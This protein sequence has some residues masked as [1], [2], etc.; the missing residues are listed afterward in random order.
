M[1][2]TWYRTG[3]LTLTKGSAVAA[4]VNTAFLT[5]VRAGDMLIGPLMDM[6]EITEVIAD[7]QLRLASEYKGDDYTGPE[8]SVAPTTVQLKALALQI[9]SLVTLYQEVPE[10]VAGSALAAANSE[11]A[12]KA[13]EAAAKAS[14]TAAKEAQI[15]TTSSVTQAAGYRD[16]ALTY[17]NNANAA[18]TNAKAS[19]NSAKTSAT[20]AKTSETNAKASETNAA[21]SAAAAAT[22]VD[23]LYEDVASAQATANAA[24]PSLQKGTAGGVA[25]LNERGNITVR[26]E[27]VTLPSYRIGPNNTTA[28]RFATSGDLASIKHSAN[29]TTQIY[30][31]FRVPMPNASGTMMSLDFKAQRLGSGLT[32]MDCTVNLY[33]L[34]TPSI[35]NCHVVHR[36]NWR[37][38]VSV[39]V[40][41]GGELGIVFDVN[42]ANSGAGFFLMTLD[43]A[44]LGHVGAVDGFAWL[45]NWVAEAVVDFS[46]FTTAPTALPDTGP[47]PLAGGVMTGPLLLPLG[48]TSAA[49]LGVGAANTGLYSGAAGADVTMTVNGSARARVT[50]SDTR[51]V[52]PLGFGGSVGASDVTLSRTGVS[53]LSVGAANGTTFSGVVNIGDATFQLSKGTAGRLDNTPATGSAAIYLSANPGDSTST[54][55]IAINRFSST[56]GANGLV[57]YGGDGTTA[58]DHR[59]YGGGTVGGAAALA[60]IAARGGRVGIGGANTAGRTLRVYGDTQIDARL[61]IGSYTIA[62]L[63]TASAS[64]GAMAICSNA[65]G[66][67][68]VAYCDGTDWISLKTGLPVAVKPYES[69]TI[70][71]SQGVTGDWTA[72]RF[73]DGSMDFSVKFST[74][75][76]ALAG[77][78]G[79]QIAPTPM[80]Y[81]VTFT[82]VQSIFHDYS[83]G[84]HGTLKTS[85]PLGVGAAPLPTSNTGALYISTM[86]GG[87]DAT[88]GAVHFSARGRW[89][90]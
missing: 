24:I 72:C 57:V 47:M 44:R 25:A 79:V 43:A 70:T 69:G 41:T 51:L 63:P 73:P 18:E 32:G 5:N 33:V 83:G 71:P 84:W 19:E 34:A 1:A 7:S 36:G 61:F 74:P 8:W 39:G 54:A 23:T 85:S 46:S 81:P 13:S 10:D 49:A 14:E 9:A 30:A 4:G 65:Q 80:T 90:A 17:S 11:A 82:S 37:P 42:G 60:D 59:L 12:A 35:P 62:T 6:Y 86:L 50:A 68:S 38:T 2:G 20:N 88:S 16:N 67:A 53:A 77:G 45:S 64:S 22:S 56:S 75:V 40:T 87:T 31:Q 58:I 76:P 29:E 78:T 66:G 48:G 15:A 27:G 55:L 28:R 89:K 26:Q 21:N 52:G 3:T